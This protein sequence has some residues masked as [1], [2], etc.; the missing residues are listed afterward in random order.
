VVDL[1]YR[2]LIWCNNWYIREETLQRAT[3]DL[4]NY[5]YRQPLSHYWGDGRFSS[6]DG[7]R[8]AVAVRTQ[9]AAPLPRYFGY[10]RGLTFLT[11]TSNQYSQ[12]GTLVTPP[13]HREAAYTL[14]KILDN[15]TDLEIQAHTTDTEGYTDLIFA[16]FDLLGMQF[17]PRIKDISDAR[18][19]TIDL[20]KPYQHLQAIISRRLNL[21]IIHT[22]WPLML[23]L[24]ASLKFRWTTPSLL[25]RK[26][27]A[28]PRQHVLTQALQEYGRLIKTIFI[29]HYFQSE[30]YRRRIG[31]QLNKGE[32]L[33][34]LRS[35]IHSANRGRIRKKYPEEHLNQA[36]CLN[37][38]VNAVIVWNTV[39][40]Q[41]AI[42]HLRQMG[43][44]ITEEELAQLS[45]VR[46]E[47][48]NVYGKYSFDL[49][50]PLTEA[51]LRPLV[52]SS[53]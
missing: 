33:H 38:I 42:Q 49:T 44:T 43:Q 52:S 7:Q 14:D 50:G 9:N 1:S 29:L 26:L 35:H 32:K 51:G 4:V 18:L 21:D 10:G 39:Y 20:Q 17:A 41:V 19:Y 3:N 11:W 53:S 5:Q 2:Q 47:H 16:L 25:I 13:T 40:M 27:Q 24:A 46:F 12:Y 37:L 31:A 36:N 48:I 45:P 8:F 30:A 15:D 22:N 28:F 6:S 34:A 23:R